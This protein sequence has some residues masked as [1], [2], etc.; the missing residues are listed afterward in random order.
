MY[1]SMGVVDGDSAWAASACDMLRGQLEATDPHMAAFVVDGD[2]GGLAACAIGQLR[3]RLPSPGDPADL[4]GYISN[5]CTDHAHRRRGYAR[6][7]VTGLIDWFAGRGV[8]RIDLRASA[9]AEPLYTS[10]GF[11][12]TADPAMRLSR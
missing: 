11:K 2:D 7:C 8:T 6:A 9:Q 5:V 3:Q 4:S 1:G 12:R 10:L